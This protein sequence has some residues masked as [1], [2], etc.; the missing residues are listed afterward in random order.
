MQDQNE[1]DVQS[2][3]SAGLRI[4]EPSTSQTEELGNRSEGY[5]SPSAIVPLPKALPRKTKGGRKKG[6]TRILTSTPVRNEIAETKMHHRQ[7]KLQKDSKHLSTKK[8]LFGHKR[9]R[10]E[11]EDDDDS[12]SG[13]E[14]DM[15]LIDTDDDLESDDETI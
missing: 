9:K 4:P 11:K 7:T 8:Q 3:S 13:S 2:T 6:T 15:Q 1:A 10:H 12:S 5:I 14:K